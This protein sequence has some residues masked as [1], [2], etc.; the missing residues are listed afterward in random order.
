LLNI[1]VNGIHEIIFRQ[2]QF[3]QGELE[4]IEPWRMWPL[5]VAAPSPHG[6]LA[7]IGVNAP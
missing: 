5:T 2:L 6:S 3:F 7:S 4:L 1:E